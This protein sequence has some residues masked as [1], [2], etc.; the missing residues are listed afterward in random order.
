MRGRLNTFWAELGK[1]DG[2]SDEPLYGNGGIQ[3]VP[4]TYKLPYAIARKQAKDRRR[5]RNIRM[6]RVDP[7]GPLKPAA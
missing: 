1:Q 5:Q 2:E 3:T 6:L 7:I 4:V